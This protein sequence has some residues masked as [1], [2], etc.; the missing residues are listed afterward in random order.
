MRVAVVGTGISGMVAAHLLQREHELTVYEAG[1]SVG[2]HTNTVDVISRGRTLPVDTGFIVFN[3]KTYPNFVRLLLELGVA[4]Q[5]SDMSFSVRCEQSSLEY[6]GSSL[7][8]LFAQRRNLLRPSFLRMVTEILRF[9]RD[10]AEVLEDPDLDVSLGEYLRLR[11]YSAAFVEKH[12]V[13]MAAAVWSSDRGE[14]LEFPV[15]FLVRFFANHGFLQV[16]DRPQWL[17]VCGGSREYVK[18]LTA[19][20]RDRIRLRTPVV[21]VRR[22]PDRVELQTRDGRVERFDQVVLATHSDQALR[23]LADPSRAETEILGALRYQR[24]EAVLHTD[25]SLLPRRRRAWSSWNYHLVPGDRDRVRVSYWMNRLQDLTAEDDFL[26]TL[27]HT[28]PIAP[29]KIL[30]K[31]VYHHPIFSRA[32]VRAQARRGEINGVNRTWFCG[33]YWRNGFH[34]DGVVSA[35]AVAEAF[36]QELAA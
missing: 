32:G 23:L 17:T 22:H 29:G 10:A 8:G 36:G 3:E 25:T 6:N 1:E 12:I 21:S 24:N 27:N 16:K 28:A 19:S 7:N 5:E 14:L 18:K 4:W 35:L 30:K 33:A 20:Y 34:E 15:R 26:V 11:G 31:I 2:G 9:Y 13:P